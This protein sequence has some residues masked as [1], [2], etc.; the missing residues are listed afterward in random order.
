VPASS[1][2]VLHVGVE[3][4][5]DLKA[6]FRFSSRSC[7]PGLQILPPTPLSGQL[8]LQRLQL[9]AVFARLLLQNFQVIHP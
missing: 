4:V 9:Q 1:H 6:S 2:L 3:Q 5:D 7:Q 8:M